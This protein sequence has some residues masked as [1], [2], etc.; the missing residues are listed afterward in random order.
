MERVY[1]REYLNR[2]GAWQKLWSLNLPPKMLHFVWRL[3]R[4]VLPL[5]TILRRRRIEVPSRCGLCGNGDETS[6][7]VFGTCEV[8]KDC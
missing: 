8:A 2:P 3:G 4:G 5:R 6:L 7:H 1:Q